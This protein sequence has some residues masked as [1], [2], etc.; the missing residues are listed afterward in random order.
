[1]GLDERSNIHSSTW[2]WDAASPAAA[3]KHSHNYLHH[4][5]TNVIGK[6]RDVGYDI[7]RVDPA[8]QWHPVYLLQPFYNL[9]LM[10][11]FEWGIA[12]YDFLDLRAILSGT[13]PK[14]QVRDEVRALGRKARRQIIKDFVAYPALSGAIGSAPSSGT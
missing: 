2:E 12:T 13:K 4:T 9:L 7:L 1:M 11:L 3:W 10:A 8:Q 14:D 6:D 5:Y